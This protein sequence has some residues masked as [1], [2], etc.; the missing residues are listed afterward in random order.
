[1]KG[2]W[3]L[4]CCRFLGRNEIGS[5]LRSGCNR[6]S[7]IYRRQHQWDPSRMEC[8]SCGCDWESDFSYSCLIQAHLSSSWPFSPPIRSFPR[9]NEAVATIFLFSPTQ[10]WS[11]SDL[12]FDS[13]HPL[14]VQ[15][16]I[17]NCFPYLQKEYCNGCNPPTLSG[18]SRS[19][20]RALCDIHI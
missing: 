5:H 15:S 18:L 2:S 6:L 3:K 9:S 14:Y 1:M 10:G 12:Y 19:L 13:H 4:W 16:C 20:S 17:V 11:S 7:W 8:K